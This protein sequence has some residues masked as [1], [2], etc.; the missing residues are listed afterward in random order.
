[1]RC[2][3]VP[4]GAALSPVRRPSSASGRVV[5][6]GLFSAVNYSGPVF[7]P[8]LQRTGSRKKGFSKIAVSQDGEMPKAALR[9]LVVCLAAPVPALRWSRHR[10]MCVFIPVQS[11]S[12]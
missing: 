11:R 2:G 3:A 9:S 4:A 12:V 8:L 10:K 5:A 1:M 6:V 7:S